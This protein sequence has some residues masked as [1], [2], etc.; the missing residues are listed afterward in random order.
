MVNP[1]AVHME[2]QPVGRLVMSEEAIAFNDLK[3]TLFYDEV[4]RPQAATIARR[5]LRSAGV[6][7]AGIEGFLA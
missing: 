3:R 4:L 5:I 7:E 6:A 2:N 1:W